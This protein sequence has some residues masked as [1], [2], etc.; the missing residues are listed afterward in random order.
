MCIRVSCAACG[1]A[2]YAGCG[3]H[4]DRVLAGVPA[5]E[6]CQC[7]QKAPGPAANK[8]AKSLVARLVSALKS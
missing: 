8:G 1:K 7:R 2:T 3:A 5:A 4:V 6:R